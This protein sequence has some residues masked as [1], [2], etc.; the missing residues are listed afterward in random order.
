MTRAFRLALGP[1]RWGLPFHRPSHG[2]LACDASS[3]VGRAHLVHI[4]SPYRHTRANAQSNQASPSEACGAPIAEPLCEVNRSG[5]WR[6]CVRVKGGRECFPNVPR[7]FHIEGA[8]A[9]AAT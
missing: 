9:N 5:Y 4:A 6:D 8:R 1:G 3:P 2:F 7:A